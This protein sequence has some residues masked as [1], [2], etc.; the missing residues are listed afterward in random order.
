[1]TERQRT[2]MEVID[3]LSMMDFPSWCKTFDD[4]VAFSLTVTD[5]IRHLMREMRK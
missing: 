1:M 3:Y 5:I 4:Q 2:L